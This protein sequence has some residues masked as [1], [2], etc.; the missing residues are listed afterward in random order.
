M[1]FFSVLKYYIDLFPLKLT[2]HGILHYLWSAN[3]SKSFSIFFSTDF[4]RWESLGL[5]HI[6]YIVIH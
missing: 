4:A 5:P 1:I 2:C 3:L 6:G